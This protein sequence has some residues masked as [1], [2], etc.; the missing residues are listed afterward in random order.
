MNVSEKNR[1]KTVSILALAIYLKKWISI[2]Q[3]DF[4]P[5]FSAAVLAGGSCF[6]AVLL[7]H[8]HTDDILE[9]I[10]FY[11]KEWFVCIVQEVCWLF[12]ASAQC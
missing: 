5:N 9:N 4:F 8:I 10:N 1:A 6:G 3:A 7:R 12:G 2:T 11:P